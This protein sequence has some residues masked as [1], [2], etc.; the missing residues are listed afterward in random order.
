MADDTAALLADHRTA[1]R[2]MADRL[3]A[4]EAVI[5]QVRA[6]HSRS[7]FPASRGEKRGQHYCIEC[8]AHADDRVYVVWPCATA[9]VLRV[10]HSPSPAPSPV[11]AE[12][13]S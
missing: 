5:E 8:T 11:S 2:N 12:D 3:V 10:A 4:A 7:L 13:G 9:T 6:L 1:L